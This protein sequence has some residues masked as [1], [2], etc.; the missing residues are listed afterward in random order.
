MVDNSYRYTEELALMILI[1][2]LIINYN[3]FTVTLGMFPPVL[4][5]SY[6]MQ[7]FGGKSF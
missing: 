4:L 6:G 1:L 2:S 7:S 5:V 3:T